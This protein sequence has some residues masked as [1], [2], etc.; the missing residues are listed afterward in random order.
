M[1][2]KLL[3]IG[4]GVVIGMGVVVIKDVLLGVIV[5]GNLVVLL[6]KWLV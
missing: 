3:M 6:M 5:V 1:F 4:K 2:D